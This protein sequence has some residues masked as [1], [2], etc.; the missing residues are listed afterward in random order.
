MDAPTLS[1]AGMPTMVGSYSFVA[2][3]ID[4]TGGSAARTLTITIGPRLQLVSAG[5]PNGLVA[6]QYSA[7]LS[8]TGG[9]SSAYRWSL[10]SGTLPPGLA[11]TSDGATATLAGKP[12]A[13]GSFH[14]TLAVSLSAVER[15]TTTLDVF[16]DRNPPRIVTATLPGA[17][18]GVPYAATVAAQSPSGGPLQW[19]V[20][21]GSLPTGLTL[22]AAAGASA[23][24][25]G[26][27]RQRGTFSFT[28]SIS[29]AGGGT[30]ASY[31]VETGALARLEVLAR[32]FHPARVGKPY[33]A[34]V[35]S[36]GAQGGLVWRL[37]SGQLPPGLSLASDGAAAIVQGTP[38]QDG[39]Y[40]FAVSATDGTGHTAQQRFA[41]HVA[42]A[43]WWVAMAHTAQFFAPWTVTVRDVSGGTPGAATDLLSNFIAGT[44]ALVNDLLFSPNPN[45]LSFTGGDLQQKTLYLADLRSTPKV[46]KLDGRL[47]GDRG[48]PLRWAPDGTRFAY[49][50]EPVRGSFEFLHFL[51]DTGTS[52]VTTVPIQVL[53]CGYAGIWSPDSTRYALASADGTTL[54]VAD[55]TTTRAVALPPD[56]RVF[57][58]VAWTP[59]SAGLLFSG[60]DRASRMTKIYYLDLATDAA[61][62]FAVTPAGLGVNP[63][64]PIA[65]PDG[66]SIAVFRDSWS[67]PE[68]PY[69]IDL[70]SPQVGF[71][72]RV[73]TSIAGRFS[74]SWSPDSRQLAF[75]S[76][77]TG[78]Q[79]AS[80]V[81]LSVIDRDQIGLSPAV[82][83]V[84][85]ILPPARR[86][87]WTPDG[88]RL[89]YAT[90]AGVFAVPASGGA[91]DLI[92]AAALRDYDWLS[93][94]SQLF[95]YAAQAGLSAIDMASPSPRSPLLL[96]GAGVPDQFA[97]ARARKAVFYMRFGIDRAPS[98]LWMV[99]LGA[100]TPAAPFELLDFNVGVLHY[101]VSDDAWV[102][103]D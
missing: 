58:L 65:S 2:S 18:W 59:D 98:K 71:A 54:Y 7:T 101:V 29:D 22:S 27:P 75:A 19:Q 41:I 62:A 89:L 25:T 30:S 63:N 4:A 48:W 49:A 60:F 3:V 15:A 64:F 57:S 14:F 21:A 43:R 8:A 69:V 34:R 70:R 47:R 94:D 6:A 1:L 61:Q 77:G 81:E 35:A 83:L 17:T 99:D 36:G 39:F 79:P 40:R 97:L 93:G 28:I 74:I 42:A 92:V 52:A 72:Q 9:S 68:A 12:T 51:G 84:D 88:Q 26:T 56:Q 73:D 102:G 76:F 50:T 55:G 100:S 85:S 96:D 86:V 31:V 5:F 13:T 20:S 103:L 87:T 66:G 91:P 78:L 37:D 16:I 45:L 67:T 11:L 32:T 38:T 33:A 80:G 46:V 53:P 10:D 23:T 82:A 24:L 95:I 44:F 90:D